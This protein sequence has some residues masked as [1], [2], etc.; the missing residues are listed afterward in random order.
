MNILIWFL[1][2]NLRRGGTFLGGLFMPY[3]CQIEAELPLRQKIPFF[4]L[5]MR[6]RNILYLTAAREQVN[7][8]T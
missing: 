1:T 3:Y 5:E 4:L 2:G 6:T 7:T 8:R